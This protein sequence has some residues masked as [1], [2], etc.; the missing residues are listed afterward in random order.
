MVSKTI[1]IGKP[2]VSVTML[3]RSIPIITGK[4]A[5]KPKARV[6]GMIKIT[7]TNSSTNPTKGKSHLTVVIAAKVSFKDSDISA[8]IGM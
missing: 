4:I 5:I 3:V 1:A 7:P 2:E 6:F 8:G